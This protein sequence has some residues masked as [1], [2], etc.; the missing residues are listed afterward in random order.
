[1]KYA[2]ALTEVAKQMLKE[3]S[4]F[5]NRLSLNFW[6]EVPATRHEL[7]KLKRQPT[8]FIRETPHGYSSRHST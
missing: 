1:M 3:I 6:N 5:D 7:L 8:N 4:E 2:I